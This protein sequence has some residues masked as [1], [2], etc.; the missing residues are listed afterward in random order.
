VGLL[1][2]EGRAQLGQVPEN[3]VGRSRGRASEAGGAQVGPPQRRSKRARAGPLRERS[4]AWP[5]AD[6]RGRG[7][8]RALGLGGVTAIVFYSSCFFVVMYRE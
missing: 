3:K 4:R 8:E 2:Q 1:R 7:R 6:A 5:R